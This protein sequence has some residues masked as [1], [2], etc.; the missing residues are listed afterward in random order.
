VTLGALAVGVFIFGLPA[1]IVV[2]IVATSLGYRL[3]QAARLALAGVLVL[4]ILK[5]GGAF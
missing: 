1:Y 2:T 3:S 4:L 5:A